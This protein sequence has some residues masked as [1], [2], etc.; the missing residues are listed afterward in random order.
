M[1]AEYAIPILVIITLGF[2]LQ[3]ANAEL[4]GQEAYLVEGSGFAVTEDSI[5]I[6]EIDF[7]VEL[8]RQVGSRASLTV[9]DG[10][11]T[12]G[13]MDYFVSD[14]TGTVLN[15]GRFIRIAGT[16]SNDFGDEVSISFFGRIV[17]DSTEG[18]VYSF[19]GRISEGF[20]SSKIIYTSKVSQITS[21]SLTTDVTTTVSTTAT[22]FDELEDNEILVTITQAADQQGLGLDW[23]QARAAA[24]QATFEQGDDPTRARYLFPNRLTISP[25]TILTFQNDDN[26]AHSIVSAKRDTNARGIGWEHR[27][28]P[29][30]RVNS[31]E[32]PPGESRSVTINEVGFIFLVDPDYLWVRM[33]VVS[34]PDASESIVIRSAN[35]WKQKGN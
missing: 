30:G 14:I 22:D 34:F 13:D 20:F 31:G 26:V 7:L 19:T 1:K 25:G 3:Q 15:D 5:K 2:S 21:S 6:S 4:V 28:F 24:T 32:I 10:F 23:I 27:M 18:S 12:L 35:A 16:A 9:Q 29:D 33:D 17:E 8:D 11:V